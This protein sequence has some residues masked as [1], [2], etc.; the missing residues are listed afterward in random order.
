V[1]GEA[2][3]ELGHVSKRFGGLRVLTDV[4]L[5]VVAG[6]VQALIG[7]NG[8]GKTTLLNIVSGYLAPDTGAVRFRG[9]DVTGWPA[10]RRVAGGLA[11]TFQ[12]VQVFGH[13]TVLENVLCGFHLQVT[14]SP[15]GAVLGLRGVRAE[16]RRLRE[17]GRELLALV[18]LASSADEPAGVLPFGLQRRL[19]VARALATRPAMLLLDEPCAGLST[20]EVHDLAILLRRLAADGMALLVVEHH[21]PFVLDVAER[22]AVLDSGELIADG[23][24]GAIRAN[25]RVVEAYLGESVHVHA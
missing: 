5:D 23:P 18:D 1:K 8:A 21:M 9:R 12:I 24:P 2:I 17:R 20:P 7:P 14:Q 3:L 13:M 4:S 15:L 6:T 11:R 22:V 10:S 19:E 25:P 16:E